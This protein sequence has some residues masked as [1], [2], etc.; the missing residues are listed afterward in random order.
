VIA[1]LADSFIE[2][3]VSVKGNLHLLMLSIGSTEDGLGQKIRPGDRLEV[4]LYR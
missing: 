4:M 2:G 3:R 1:S